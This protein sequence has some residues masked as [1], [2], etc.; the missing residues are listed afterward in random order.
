MLL[1]LDHFFKYLLEG[2]FNK[3]RGKYG[4]RMRMSSQ[5]V[6][7][8]MLLQVGNNTGLV[9][10]VLGS[11]IRA[12]LWLKTLIVGID[13]AIWKLK[14]IIFKKFAGVIMKFFNLLVVYIIVKLVRNFLN[15]EFSRIP[16]V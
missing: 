16:F 5:H 1:V 6:N 8:G 9:M 14:L 10:D 12:E 7:K 4:N 11:L 13:L 3:H 15:K 2:H